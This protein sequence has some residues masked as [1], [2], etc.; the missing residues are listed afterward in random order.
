M[1]RTVFEAIVLTAF[2]ASVLSWGVSS[3]IGRRWK[4][5]ERLGLTI[6]LVPFLA[7]PLFIATTEGISWLNYYE[8][9]RDP[10]RVP[11]VFLVSI[12]PASGEVLYVKGESGEWLVCPMKNEQD[13]V[14]WCLENDLREST[15]TTGVS[16]V[17]REFFPDRRPDRSYES[18]IA[19]N[20]A[21][22]S[23]WYF[24]PESLLVYAA[25]YW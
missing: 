2:A 17:P 16:G 8:G 6:L 10:D 9:K 4:W 25:G 19:L 20:G 5:S 11:D 14:L 21:G 15:Q 13:F 7:A 18:E 23:A 1:F 12:P 24:R 3:W 22:Q